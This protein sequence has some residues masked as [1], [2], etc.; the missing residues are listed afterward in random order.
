MTERNLEYL[1]VCGSNS[2]IDA[3]A[4][5]PV[6]AVAALTWP[7]AAAATT[8]VSGSA[9]DDPMTAVPAAGTGAWTMQVGGLVA[10]GSLATEVVALNGAAA[11]TCVNAYLRLLPH[12]C[13]VLTAGT[14]GT[15]A[16]IISIKHASTTLLTIPAGEGRADGAFFTVPLR[17]RGRLVRSSLQGGVATAGT[18]TGRVMVRPSGGAWRSVDLYEIT[19]SDPGRQSVQYERGSIVLEALTDVYLLAAASVNNMVAYGSLEATLEDAF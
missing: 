4:S 5:E 13:R 3:A 8:V 6:A 12:L 10:D 19:A 11:V 15:N 14:G 17:K 2:D 9:E 18:L 1:R 16:G 7:T